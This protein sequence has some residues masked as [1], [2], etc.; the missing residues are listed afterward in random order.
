MQGTS[1][2]L[3]PYLTE[4]KVTNYTEEGIRKDITLYQ[5]RTQQFTCLFQTLQSHKCPKVQLPFSLVAPVN[6]SSMVKLMNQVNVF[7]IN[8]SVA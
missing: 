2:L 3:D 5:K 6:S 1:N 7:N 8:L 4:S